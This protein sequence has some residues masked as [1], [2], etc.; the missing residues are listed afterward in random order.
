MCKAIQLTG[1]STCS[2]VFTWEDVI[3]MEPRRQMVVHVTVQ[4][5]LHGHTQRIFPSAGTYRSHAEN[6]PFRGLPLVTHRE[7]SPK[8][9]PSF[10][11]RAVLPSRYLYR[12][13]QQKLLIA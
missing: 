6:I 8:T 7:Y 4:L 11:S 1:I 3:Y 2:L 5:Y 10:F 9:I 13:Q 12:Q